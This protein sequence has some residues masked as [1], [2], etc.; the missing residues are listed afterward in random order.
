MAKPFSRIYTV[1][2][3]NPLAT[4]IKTLLKLPSWWF[5]VG[6]IMVGNLQAINRNA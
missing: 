5:M 1:K 3:V 2:R 6:R 4:P